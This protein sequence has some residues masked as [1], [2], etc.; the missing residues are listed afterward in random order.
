MNNQAHED[1]EDSE[2]SLHTNINNQFLREKLL[3]VFFEA[4]PAKILIGL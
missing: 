3:G 1:F 4:G 2:C